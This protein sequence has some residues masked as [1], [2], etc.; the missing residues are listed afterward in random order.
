MNEAPQRNRI[1]FT[2]NMSFTTS[3]DSF[4]ILRKDGVHVSTR[5]SNKHTLTQKNFFFT[6]CPANTTMLQNPWFVETKPHIFFVLDSASAS[7][8][9]RRDYMEDRHMN[10]QL[11]VP[12][13][14]SEAY[15]FGVYDGHC[16]DNTA[17]YLKQ[18]MHQILA[19]QPDFRAYPMKKCT[20]SIF[21]NV[22]YL[23]PSFASR[24]AWHHRGSAHANVC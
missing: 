6:R 22:T 18:N 8:S 12:A 24:R 13:H 21:A 20:K 2:R 5:V 16:G 19:K 11:S 7:T 9:G 3:D 17:E 4:G 10:V 15:Y 14:D 23:P 1:N